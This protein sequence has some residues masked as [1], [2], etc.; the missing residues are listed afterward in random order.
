MTLRLGVIGMS[1]GNGHPYSWSAI[2]NG[3]DKEQMQNC[4]FPVIPQYLA[5]Q[6]W[7]QAKINGAR[8]T[9]IWTQESELSQKI[10]SAALIENIVRQPEEML[11]VVDAVLLARDDAEKHLKF[12]TPFIK[13]G[14]P[15][16]IDKPVA[17]SIAAFEELYRLEKYA[18]QIFTCSALRYSDE[19]KL[20]LSDCQEIGELLEIH[21]ITP[22]SW[23]K[24]AVHII[25]PVLA[26]LNSMD[27]IVRLEK[28]AAND[29]GGALTVHWQSGVRTRFFAIGESAVAPI[30]I[31]VIGSKGWKDLVFADSFSAFKAALQDFVDGVRA[32]SVNSL[33][34]FNRK[35]VGLIEAGQGGAQ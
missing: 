31:R 16:Y 24:Y 26:M 11:G 28:S 18:G 4:E 20:S 21:A 34:E 2:F 30:S 3:Y 27:K 22:K 35:V 12:A 9:H 5:Q 1:K 6:E 19:L 17:L 29:Q 10:A 25:E 7:P 13:A 14:M 32:K 33:P 8:V 15:I 23:A